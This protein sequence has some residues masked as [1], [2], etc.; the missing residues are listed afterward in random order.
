MALSR[1][2]GSGPEWKTDYAAVQLSLYLDSWALP[3]G[4]SPTHPPPC[5]GYTAVWTKTPPVLFSNGAKVT[6]DEL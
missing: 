1:R 3:F 6:A 4:T 5:L 2:P